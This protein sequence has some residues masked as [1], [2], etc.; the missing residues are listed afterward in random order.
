MITNVYVSLGCIAVAAVV[1]GASVWNS[2]RRNYSDGLQ[3]GIIAV[4]IVNGV[5]AVANLFGVFGR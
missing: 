5:I 3:L 2:S 1:V 4:A